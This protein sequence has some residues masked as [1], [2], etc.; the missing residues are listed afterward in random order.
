MVLTAGARPEVEVAIPEILIR[1]IQQG[2]AATATFDAVPNRT[3]TGRVT[4]VGV[5]AT[6][7]MTTYPVT[8]ELNQSDSRLLP[9]MAGE[10]TFYFGGD[11]AG[12]RY[13]VPP[14]AVVQDR[15]GRF[16]FVVTEEADGLGVVERRPVVTGKLIGAGLEV[17]EGLHDGEKVV[18][19]GASRV[20]DGQQ[21]RVSAEHEG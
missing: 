16:L 11:G 9:G 5:A 6:P 17:L 18:V 7:G 12:A 4:E 3:F 14:H 8:V 20:Q 19:T 21:V 2:A 13:V 10:V 1:E 15:D